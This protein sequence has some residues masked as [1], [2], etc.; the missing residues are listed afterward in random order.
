MRAGKPTAPLPSSSTALAAASE[1]SFETDLY[2]LATAWA[3]KDNRAAVHVHRLG[4]QGGR[5]CERRF[6]DEKALTEAAERLRAATG[7]IAAWHPTNAHPPA[8]HDRELVYLVLGQGT[9][10]TAPLTAAG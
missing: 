2:A 4:L 5:V 10:P 1:T 7:R 3:V 6:Y 8:V 9:L